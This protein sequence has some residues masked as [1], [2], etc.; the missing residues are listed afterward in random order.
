MKGLKVGILVFAVMGLLTL[1][2]PAGGHIPLFSA[3]K[4]PVDFLQFLIIF[5]LPCAMAIMGITKPPMQMWQTAVAAGG[6]GFGFIKLEMWNVLKN[7]THIFDIP[8]IHA[9]LV[10]FGI[11]GGV[12]VSILA[13][14][15]P[16]PRA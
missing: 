7:I 3:I 11:L 4:E 8:G 10:V 2:I 9:K 5:G 6:F 12:I 13:L 16:E 1:V 15:K 14:V